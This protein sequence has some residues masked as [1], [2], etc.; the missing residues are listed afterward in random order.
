[1]CHIFVVDFIPVF[2]LKKIYE[3]I[4]SSVQFKGHD[5]ESWVSHGIPREEA[6]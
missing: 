2:L 5:S 6:F 3:N 1:M 4:T